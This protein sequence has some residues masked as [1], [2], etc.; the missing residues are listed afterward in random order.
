MTWQLHLELS[1]DSFTLDISLDTDVPR[2]AIIGPNGT[3]KTTLLRSI[4]G[5]HK[6]NTGLIKVGTDV[7]YD[8]ESELSLP[9]DARRVGYVPQNF[10]LF[11]N[12]TV[13]AN[14]TYGVD[15]KQ[16]SGPERN[17]QAMGLLK[18]MDCA[19]LAQQRPHTLSIG[20]QQRVALARALMIMPRCLLLDE[21]L[22]ALDVR[23]RRQ[24]RR[25]LA[26][27]L[28]IHSTPTLVVT[29]DHRDVSALCDYVCVMEHGRIVQ[30]GQPNDV[31]QH[32]CNDFVAEFFNLPQLN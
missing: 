24:L 16:K 19:D 11:P 2:V 22:A 20:Q 10:A 9:V 14:L 23:A 21:P 15:P 7:F 32:P 30:H 8:H 5:A 17:Q 31:M 26:G 1:L 27:Y 12:L 29:H 25:L 4:A 13:L 18:E 28:R 6:L 3:G